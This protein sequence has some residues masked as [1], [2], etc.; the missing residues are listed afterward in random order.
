MSDPDLV[1]CRLYSA[2][3]RLRTDR[4]ID[5]TLASILCILSAAIGIAGTVMESRPVLAF[6][7][8]FLWPTLFSITIMGYVSYKRLDLNLDGKL[9]E[10]WSRSLG[11]EGRKE[12]QDA[13]QC[14]G[15]Y[16][17]LRESV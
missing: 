6:Y 9:N 4:S 3:G 12:I 16:S 13:L 2:I 5:L 10:S 14:C 1:I 8:L 17:S 7:N 15:Y 11:P